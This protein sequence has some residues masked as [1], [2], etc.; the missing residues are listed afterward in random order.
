MQEQPVSVNSESGVPW[1]DNDKNFLIV[2]LGASAGGINALKEF[3][4]RI[5]ADSGMAYVVILH[6]SPDYDSKLAQVLQVVSKIPVQKVEQKTIIKPDNVYVIPP[7]KSLKMVDGHI[8]ISPINTVEERRAPVDIFFRTLAETHHDHA[9][10]VILSGTGANG[11]MGLKRIKENGGAAFVQ[12]PKQAEYNEMPGN[13][14]RG[15]AGVFCN[16]NNTW[17]KGLRLRS[18][19]FTTASTTFSKGAA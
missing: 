10:A 5:P 4:E 7:D 12:D 8:T 16:A 2:G 19:S 17:N 6:L 3:F 14:I 13:A 9:V 15:M 18:L 1:K 11:S